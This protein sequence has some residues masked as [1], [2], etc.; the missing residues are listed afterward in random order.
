MWLL[1]FVS[2]LILV[3]QSSTFLISETTCPGSF[4]AG[5]FAADYDAFFFMEMDAVPVRPGWIDQFLLEA[6]AMR[7]AIRGSSYRGEQQGEGTIFYGKF[8][9]KWQAPSNYIIIYI[10][11]C[12]LCK[13]NVNEIFGYSSRCSRLSCSVELHHAQCLIVGCTGVPKIAW[14]M[15]WTI[16]QLE[17][18]FWSYVALC[19]AI[20]Q[21]FRKQTTYV[22]EISS[23][24]S[25][26]MYGMSTVADL[27]D[28]GRI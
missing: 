16:G 14:K 17:S 3:V 13:C 26:K 12:N 5:D 4:Y 8:G 1:P 6:R 24:D 25:S 27:R 19:V 20:N 7:G 28:A 11:K 2:E 22:Q 10:Y 9:M 23:K 15:T 18:F 21:D